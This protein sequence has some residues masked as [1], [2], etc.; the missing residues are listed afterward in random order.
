MCDEW[1]STNQAAKLQ[2][3]D[4]E[5]T[6][7]VQ[8]K[9]G[10]LSTITSSQFFCNHEEL[11]AEHMTY[12][13]TVNVSLLGSSREELEDA[14]KEWPRM[15]R[16][17]Q[18]Q[19][20]ILHVEENCPVIF[21]SRME[22]KCEVAETAATVSLTAFVATVVVSV[23]IMILETIAIAVISIILCKLLKNK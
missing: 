13:A 12:R 11:H 2:E 15:Y 17:L 18:V 21:H 16:S 4:A 19:G 22:S 20:E 6:V 5:V 8:R 7:F 9:C 23:L 14:L 1:I 3:I 10:C